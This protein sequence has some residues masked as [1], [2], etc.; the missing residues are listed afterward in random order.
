MTLRAQRLWL[1]VAPLLL[2]RRFWRSA[3]S[4]RPS[5]CVRPAA[6]DP[7]TDWCYG[8]KTGWGVFKK[9]D[10]GWWEW[11]EPE[12][13]LP[14]AVAQFHE[15]LRTDQHVLLYDEGRGYWVRLGAGQ[16][17]ISG[18]GQQWQFLFNRTNAPP[19]APGDSKQDSL[20]ADLTQPITPESRKQ[21][22]RLIETFKQRE[23]LWQEAK[24]L[25]TAGKR[26]EAIAAGEKVL[27][28]EQELCPTPR[29]FQAEV[30]DWLAS[31]EIDRDGFAAALTR[32]RE[33]EQLRTALNGPADWRTV[34]A[35]WARN[36]AQHMRQLDAASQKALRDADLAD[37]QTGAL[38]K[39]EK[40]A[41]AL[42]I[43]ERAM[44]VRRR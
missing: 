25:R 33:L 2:A 15:L 18:D 21:G 17:T 11:K 31:C 28:I 35:K 13:G 32:Y 38:Y 7:R 36:D 29:E 19:A 22:E 9:D 43:A 41:E 34:E 26:A 8:D 24:A 37:S 1:A 27:A 10:S 14:F 23:R 30:L 4:R 12:D 6:A 42:P 20:P 5:T 39:Q 40:Y 44:E 3:S 16:A